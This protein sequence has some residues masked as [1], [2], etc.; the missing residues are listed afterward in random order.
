MK[1]SGGQEGGRSSVILV[2]P[3]VT[4]EEESESDSESSSSSVQT[5]NLPCIPVQ[6]SPLPGRCLSTRLELNQSMQRN[7]DNSFKK[8]DK[9]VIKY[10]LPLILQKR[11]YN[12]KPTWEIVDQYTPKLSLLPNQK[13]TFENQRKYCHQDLLANYIICNYMYQ[14]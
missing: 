5:I 6:I 14:F 12:G 10:K 13:Y 1:L 11:K 9:T 4:Y 2:L 3:K 7:A 8:H